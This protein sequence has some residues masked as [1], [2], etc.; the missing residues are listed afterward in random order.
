MKVLTRIPSLILLI[1]ATL[2][3]GGCPNEGGNNHAGGSA[4][5]AEEAIEMS[6]DFAPAPRMAKRT[7]SVRVSSDTS[8]PPSS[9]VMDRDNFKGRRIA[10]NHSMTVRLNPDDMK[11]RFDRD[12]QGCLARGCEVINANI[13]TFGHGYINAR[14]APKSLGDYL[15]FIAA[16]EGE[17]RAHN[18]SAQDRTVQYIDTEAKIKNL[19]SLRDRLLKL[20]ENKTVKVEEIIKVERELS[21]VQSQLDSAQ[22]T[23]RHLKQQTNNATVNTRYEAT[24][25]KIDIRYHDLGNSF[26]RAWQNFVENVATVIEFIGTIIPWL[27]IWF[28]G[29]WVLVKMFTFA[30]GKG[31]LG[32]FMFW[33]KEKA[34]DTARK[35]PISKSVRVKKKT[36]TA[37][38]K[39]K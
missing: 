2:F 14:I 38:K 25:Q 33:K 10:E 35:K 19:T 8:A 15:D 17:L 22:G 4:Y 1:G 7:S 36:K 18:V 32:K 9:M 5:M 24:H 39:K 12:L 20:L 13:D 16:G 21:R 3:L 11:A 28:A 6:A 37:T 31:R 23:M 30:F 27:P 34:L 26:R 29:L